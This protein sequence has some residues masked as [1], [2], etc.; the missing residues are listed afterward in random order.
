VKPFDAE[1]KRMS[2]RRA[3]GRL[4][5][6]GAVEGMVA[7]SVAGTEKAL[8]AAEEM[9]A[10]GLRVLAVAVGEGAEEEGLRLLGLVGIADP[11]RPEAITALAAARKAGIR[12]V[13]ITGD[14]PV[15]ARA[16]ALEMG[17][18]KPADD[19]SELVHARATPQ[20]KIET[21]R[22]WKA[23]GAIVA[24]TGDGVNDAPALREAHIGIAMGKNG[25]EVAREAADIVLADDNFASIVA[26]IREGRG[27]F[28]NIRKSIAYLLAGNT[29]ELAV[30]LVASVVGLPIP[31]VPLQLL[32]INLVTDGLPALALVMDP[33]DPDIL[34][35][36]PR[37]PDEPMLGRPEWTRIVLMGLLEASVTLSVFAWALQTRSTPEARSLAFS[38]IV[39]AELFR[40][41]SA[42]HPT[43]ILWEVGLFTNLRLLGIVVLSVLMQMGLHYI[44]ATQTLFQIEALS[45]GSTAIALCAGL[46]P[47]TV[48]ELVKLGRRL[49]R[50]RGAVA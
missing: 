23:R 45:L 17:L 44:P 3:D 18:L 47:V 7:R 38:T 31:F 35:R 40:A 39:F 29:G 2:V 41:F 14:H 37:H 36:P 1:R 28:D 15:T 10:R 16:I 30:M 49:V 19:P 48:I 20:D 9:A 42:R 33:P 21:V 26:A 6:K 34:E 13:M 32:W 50:G 43:K 4:Y 22:A 24:M 8:A 46:V 5:V 12:T 25:T 27:I 11:P